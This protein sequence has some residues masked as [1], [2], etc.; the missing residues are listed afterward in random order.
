MVLRFFKKR[1]RRTKLLQYLK[2]NRSK[3]S[4]LLSMIFLD[5]ILLPD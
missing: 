2:H 3:Q 5:T 1:K 4:Y